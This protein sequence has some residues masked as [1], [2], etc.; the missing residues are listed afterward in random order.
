MCHC[1]SYKLHSLFLT[2]MARRGSM[3]F[4]LL[5]RDVRL[6]IS[7][8]YTRSRWASRLRIAQVSSY[9]TV[10]Y[11]RADCEP[12]KP[13]FTLLLPATSNLFRK[14][15]HRAC[16][17]RYCVVHSDSRYSAWQDIH[18]AVFAMFSPS[19]SAN[20]FYAFIP[21]SFWSSFIYQNNSFLIHVY[22]TLTG[23]NFLV[24]KH[25]KMI[26][27]FNYDNRNAAIMM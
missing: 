4:D 6:T 7:T 13:W 20:A 10:G 15:K 21:N 3:K 1:I 8:Y 12:R 24:A 26:S 16:T 14:K 22:L 19:N 17:N 27:T 11:S 23:L 5:T 25:V 18:F 9:L 2:L